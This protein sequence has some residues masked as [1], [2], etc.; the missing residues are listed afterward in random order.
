MLS[1]DGDADQDALVIV[2][3]IA[4]VDLIHGTLAC[5]SSVFQKLPNCTYVSNDG[6][7]GP[8]SFTYRVSDG[9]SRPTRRRSTSR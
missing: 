3:V 9:S 7:V 4:D 8:A 1:N 2:D 6:Y 5:P